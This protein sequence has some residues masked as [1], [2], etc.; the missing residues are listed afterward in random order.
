[1]GYYG[2]ALAS[3]LSG[4]HRADIVH[5]DVKPDNAL[6]GR[7]GVAK[8]T[9]FGIARDLT[10]AAVKLTDT[11]TVIGTPGFMAPEQL[12]GQ[13][14]PLSDVFSLGVTL[15]VMLA[16]VLPRQVCSPGGRPLGILL[17]DAWE[18]VPPRF[19]GLLR[20]LCAAR[21]QDR[22]RSMK[23]AQRLIEQSGWSGATQPEP[24]R[25]GLPPLPS[26][27]F[28]TGGT[29]APRARALPPEV[30]QPSSPLPDPE[31]SDTSYYDTLPMTPASKAVAARPG[32]SE[33]TPPE[34][35][36]VGPGPGEPADVEADREA[37]AE[38][39][40]GRRHGPV[41]AL[42]VAT[43]IAALLI[44][45]LVLRPTGGPP[46]TDAETA[47]PPDSSTTTSADTASSAS[48]GSRPPPQAGP[49]TD[50]SDTNADKGG[51]RSEELGTATSQGPT[52][53][54]HGPE[55]TASSARPETTTGEGGSRGALPSIDS[56]V[57]PETGADRCAGV[58]VEE[59]RGLSSLSTTQTGC[60]EDTAHDRRHASDPDVQEAPVLL[61]NHRA[62]GWPTAVEAALGRPSL[63][64]APALA[65]AGL[66]PA[67]DAGRYSAVTR[68]ARTVWVNLDKGYDLSTADVSF[69]AEHACRASVQVV[70]SGGDPDEGVTWCGR[71]AE[72]AEQAG[73]QTA[74]IQDILDQL[75]SRVS[76]RPSGGRSAPLQRARR[77]PTTEEGEA[78]PVM[79]S[80]GEAYPVIVPR[81]R[82]PASRGA[83]ASEET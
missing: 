24:E 80:E 33:A 39:A 20:R 43:V 21:V 63:A 15:Y 47:P 16:G 10:P 70:L 68:R 82:T 61:F 44:A 69:V 56:R 14:G 19:V 6:V 52:A 79:G 40:H 41:L 53:P 22:P 37:P 45:A 65:F 34:A 54:P 49:N 50:R 8:L 57:P 7:D 5:R 27:V 60:L 11:A 35:S 29:E 75:E 36:P 12:S 30:L 58:R 28:S 38:G 64:N 25:S 77:R 83:G 71:W 31:P 76:A 26:Q 74:P 23:E 62:P 18:R 46:V 55:D 1:V 66:K 51:G 78:G 72:L 17:D 13:A 73:A 48:I 67:Y 4:V 59:L 2:R 3:A 81:G 9:D 32:R 42:I